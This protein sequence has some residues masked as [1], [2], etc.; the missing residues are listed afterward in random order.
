MWN[1]VSVPILG[2]IDWKNTSKFP[3][4]NTGQSS[5]ATLLDEA[6]LDTIISGHNHVVLKVNRF[7]KND[8]IELADDD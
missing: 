3:Y 5:S 8:I 2:V 7:K 1:V 6:G 4:P